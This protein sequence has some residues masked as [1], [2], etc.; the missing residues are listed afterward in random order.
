[1]GAQSAKAMVVAE[2]ENTAIST[3]VLTDR[4]QKIALIKSGD[5][6]TAKEQLSSVS[7]LSKQA[8][9]ESS[10]IINKLFDGVEP[11]SKARSELVAATVAQT[12]YGKSQIYKFIAAGS[13]LVKEITDGLVKSLTDLPTNIK[14]Y[15]GEDKTKNTD[16]HCDF[17]RYA[18]KIDADVD[19]I[20]IEV[21]KVFDKKPPHKYYAVISKA[22][23]KEIA[24]AITGLARKLK[25]VEA[26]GDNRAEI[27]PNEYTEAQRHTITRF[28]EIDLDGESYFRC[29]V[30]YRENLDDVNGDGDTAIASFEID[31]F[32]ILN[33]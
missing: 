31:R 1:M 15:I 21:N 23:N 33:I 26:N 30:F 19:L 17:I 20:V 27:T 8:W 18:G 2:T 6:A 5:I 4:M 7:S 22:T 16:Y 3:N 13:K 28:V 24:K 12:G 25:G 29:T 32:K 11:K 10:L 9:V 14:D